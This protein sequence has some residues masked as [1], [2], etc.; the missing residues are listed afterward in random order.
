M[1]RVYGTAIRHEIELFAAWPIGTVMHVGD[2]GFLTRRG[3]L[4]ERW[5]KLADFGITFSSQ[6]AQNLTDFDFQFGKRIDI[7]FKAAGQAP[8]AGSMLTQAQA[9]ATI[10]F[11]RSSSVVVVAHTEEESIANLNKLEQD[12]VNVAASSS[13]NWKNDFVVITATYESVGTTV[14]LASGNGSKV[15]VT[16]SAAVGV[17]FDLADAKIG[18]SASAHGQKLV[19]AL[20]RPGFVPFVRIHHLLKPWRGKPFLSRYN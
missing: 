9:G 8:Q 12:L 4:F 17:P 6:K 19:K 15:G 5:G 2:I 10:E 16:A 13:K 3:K 14:V 18:L 20:A 1:A 11:G 7:R